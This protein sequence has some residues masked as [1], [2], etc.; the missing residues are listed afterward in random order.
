MSVRAKGLLAQIHGEVRNWL[1]VPNY[2]LLDALCAT[3]LANRMKGPPVWLLIIGPSGGGKSTLMDAICGVKNSYSIGDITSQTFVSG[4]SS[5]RRSAEGSFLSRISDF[6]D[7]DEVFTCTNPKFVIM[8]DLGSLL[9]RRQDIRG[10]I[11]A[12]MRHIHDGHYEKAFGTGLYFKWKGK[13]VILAGCT[14]AW[15]KYHKA[16]RVLGERFLLWREE[17]HFYR[18]I[19]GR[20]F[21][22]SSQE[23]AMDKHLAEAMALLD[24]IPIDVTPDFRKSYEYL[25]FLCHWLTVLKRVAHRDYTGKLEGIDGPD[26]TGRF[27]GAFAMLTKALMILHSQNDPLQPE[28]MI[29]LARIAASHVPPARLKALAGIPEEGIKHTELAKRTKMHVSKQYRALQE[30]CTIGILGKDTLKKYHVMRGF[31]RWKMFATQ[32]ESFIRTEKWDPDIPSPIWE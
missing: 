4:W 22:L 15:D 21:E 17:K 28:I 1:W 13:M 27:A 31:E 9:D 2:W 14:D 29:P 11:M 18:E 20:S 6:K 5:S 23:E 10:E 19:S 24:D 26:R 32:I 12:Q 25:T 30:L 3:V 8:K 7:D 16:N